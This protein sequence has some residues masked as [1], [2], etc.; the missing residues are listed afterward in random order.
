MGRSALAA[1]GVGRPSLDGLHFRYQLLDFRR[2]RG[3]ARCGCQ[4]HLAHCEQVFRGQYIKGRCA[5]IALTANDLAG[6]E[7]T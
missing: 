2:E 6:L 5:G 4:L 7:P 1:W 3:V